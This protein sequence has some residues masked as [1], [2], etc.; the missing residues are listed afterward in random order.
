MIKYTNISFIEYYDL[1]VEERKEKPYCI[2][3][4]NGNKY[5]LVKDKLHKEDGPAA[6]LL[7]A[8]LPK[9]N[10]WYSYNEWYLYGKRYLFEEWCNKLNK[11]DEEKVFL[12]LKYS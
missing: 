1:S 3:Y 6:I 2:K 8:I 12:K 4:S 11:T 10:H 9:G 7:T 5:W